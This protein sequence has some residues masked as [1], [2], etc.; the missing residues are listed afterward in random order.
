MTIEHYLLVVFVQTFLSAVVAF[1]SLVRFRSR[2]LIIRLTGFI[3]L[4]GCLANITGW[5]LVETQTFR[6]FINVSGGIHIIISF[7][8]YSWI[9]F[10]AFHKKNTKAFLMLMMLF[11]IFA[12]FNLFFWQKTERNSYT[13]LLH[14]AI[15]I[16]YSLLYFL[17][18]MKD[19]P[20]LHIHRIPMF[21][22]NSGI[23]IFHAGTF[24]LIAFT[25]Y[26]VNVMKNNML[27]Y[28]TFHNVL[29][30]MEHV[31]ILIGLYYDLKGLSSRRG[32]IT[33]VA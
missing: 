30:I 29:N 16:V 3:F 33:P 27:I 5:L 11:M 4:A 10:I 19:L 14:S 1:L 20:S 23:L 31:I 8:L 24:F 7:C 15:L 18:L 21:W 28:W 32:K 12:L 25:S 22:F 6:R 26:L 2:D 9:Y 13:Y 17:A